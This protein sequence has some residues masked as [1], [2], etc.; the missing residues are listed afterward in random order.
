MSSSENTSFCNLE[1]VDYPSIELTLSGFIPTSSLLK[2]SL[3]S[4]PDTTMF[5]LIASKV[6]VVQEFSSDNG[7][8]TFHTSVFDNFTIGG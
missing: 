8:L 4:V 6:C 3:G 2:I 1:F 7:R 5:S